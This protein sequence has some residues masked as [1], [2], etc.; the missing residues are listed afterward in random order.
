MSQQPWLP[1]FQQ[2]K[3]QQ[4]Q[5][6]FRLGSQA[7]LSFGQFQAYQG[8]RKQ[9]FVGYGQPKFQSGYQQPSYTG[10]VQQPY[11]GYQMQMPYD[12]L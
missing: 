5:P 10:F 1:Q 12:G 9:G 3:F 11:Q 4:F 6:Q 8:P 7:Q 2:P